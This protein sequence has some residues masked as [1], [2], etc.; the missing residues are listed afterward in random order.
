MIGPFFD[1]DDDM[2]MPCVC[3]CGRVFDLH[4]GINDPYSN[5]ILC[6]KCGEKANAKHDLERQIAACEDDIEMEF[7]GKREGKK[8]LKELQRQL[9]ELDNQ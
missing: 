4:D 1:D 5:K 9:R 8:R 3:D 2:E 7:V 6:W